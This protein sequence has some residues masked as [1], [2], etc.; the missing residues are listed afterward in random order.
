MLSG[1]ILLED[2]LLLLRYFVSVCF[3]NSVCLG[4]QEKMPNLSFCTSK[5]KSINLPFA[6][7]HLDPL[8]SKF[9]K[10]FHERLLKL[11]I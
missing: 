11:I 10:V 9:D 3:R 2:M 6:C 4:A 7:T 5:Q 8:R 1:I